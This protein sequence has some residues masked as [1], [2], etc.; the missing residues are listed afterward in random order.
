MNYLKYVEHSAENLQFFLWHRSYCE[1]FERL[2]ASE[3]ALSPEWSASQTDAEV[4]QPA[5]RKKVNPEIASV[6]HGTDFAETKAPEIEKVDPFN[7]PSRTPSPED[8]RAP[9]SPTFT[10][11]SSSISGDRPVSSRSD[12][13]RKANEA[14]SE[15]GMKWKPCKS[16][17]WPFNRTTKLIRYKSLHSPS[18]KK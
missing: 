7:D 4:T 6:L 18:V 17:S 3:R 14:L 12:F 1:R 13:H 15:A 5:R 11:L 10:E 16:A 8:M 9:G 2:P